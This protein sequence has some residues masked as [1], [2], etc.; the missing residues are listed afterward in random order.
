MSGR[1]AIVVAYLA[2]T[3]MYFLTVLYGIWDVG[4]SSDSQATPAESKTF[5]AVIST[6]VYTFFWLMMIISHALTVVTSPG[7]M[8]KGYEKLHEEA[9]PKDFYKL[10]SLRESIYAEIVVKKKMRKG[11]LSKEQIPNFQEVLDQSRRS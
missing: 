1:I 3:Y 11:E 9:L 5:W 8:P 7:V 6:L 4:I 10:I 2:L